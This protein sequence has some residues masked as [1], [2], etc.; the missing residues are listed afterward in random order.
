MSGVFSPRDSKPSSVGHRRAAYLARFRSEHSGLTLALRR[1]RSSQ[2]QFSP[3]QLERIVSSGVA[4]MDALATQSAAQF[5]RLTQ[6]RLHAYRAHRAFQDEHGLTAPAKMPDILSTLLV[7]MVCGL[8]EASFTAILMITG[9]KMTILEGF[10]YGATVSSVNLAV[11]TL[12]GFLPLRFAGFKRNAPDPQAR[13]S[14]VRAVSW[15][16]FAFALFVLGILHFAAA[17]VRVT[18]SATG[19]F[20]FSAVSFGAT[21]AD[22]YALGVMAIGAVGA[23]LAVFKG[24]NGFSDPVPGYSDSRRA[25][26]ERIDADG[27]EAFADAL[28]SLAAVFAQSSD[29]SENFLAA[30]DENTHSYA[31]ECEN[32][33]RRIAG[34]N[35]LIETAC[36]DLI[37]SAHESASRQSFII[38]ER[39]APD[40]LRLDELQALRISEGPDALSLPAPQG[41]D[42]TD[43]F[44]RLQAAHDRAASIVRSGFNAFLTD[45]TRFDFCPVDFAPQTK[46]IHDA[47]LNHAPE[48]HKDR[49]NG[50]APPLR[51]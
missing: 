24:F 21:F 5:E 46:E 47:T 34:H 50:H 40:A 28:D 3:S 16:S 4:E 44:S 2:P 45:L 49:A 48:F 39:Q 1:L 27:Q 12:A 41:L 35:G 19:I 13:D 37:L 31:D 51:A 43:A 25:A 33:S 22:Y 38:G 20:D 17:R 9:G 42:Q 6:A 8:A 36:D 30:E 32:L 7:L 11:G 14:L 29:D 23:V 10:G 26:G 18:G 15:A